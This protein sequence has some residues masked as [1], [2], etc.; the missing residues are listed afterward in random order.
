MRLRVNVSIDDSSCHTEERAG[1]EAGDLCVEYVVVHVGVQRDIGHKL[2][3]SF[4]VSFPPLVVLFFGLSVVNHTHGKVVHTEFAAGLGH[5]FFKSK[6]FSS[7][8]VRECFVI[9]V[10]E[11]VRRISEVSLVKRPGVSVVINGVFPAGCKVEHTEGRSSRITV[12]SVTVD[13]AEQL[14]EVAHGRT[15]N[16]A[17]SS[18][19]TT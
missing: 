11:F 1:Y 13:F 14:S 10:V 16:N 3:P 4:D 15:D 7:K 2:I 9:L 12:G 17:E 8:I 18:N 5:S 6:F 19:R